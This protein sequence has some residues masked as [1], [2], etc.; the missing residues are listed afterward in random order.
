MP[1]FDG[2][3]LRF[4]SPTFWETSLHLGIERKPFSR[5][6]DGSMPR[7]NG[8]Q[9]SESRSGAVYFAKSFLCGANSLSAAT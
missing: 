4:F 2:R 9:F 5:Q 7:K 3:G 8:L 6:R 1:M